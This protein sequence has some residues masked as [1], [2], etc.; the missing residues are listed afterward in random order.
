M[1]VYATNAIRGQEMISSA[2]RA[3]PGI[4]LSKV[5]FIQAKY[6]KK[7]FD[8]AVAQIMAA[9]KVSK[10]SQLTV[11][12]AAAAPDGSGVQVTARPPAVAQV[13]ARDSRIY[14]TANGAPGGPAIP[15]TVTAGS[16]VKAAT[17][18]W[19]DTAPFIGGDV[20]LGTSSA[21][22]EQCTSGVAAENSST[23]EDYIITAD[24]CY[25]IGTSV[26]G[27]GDPVGDW[28]GTCGNYVGEVTSGDDYWDA[29]IID[30][31]RQW[32]TGSIS[33]EAGK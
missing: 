3:H 28:Y 25:T 21:G 12:S 20:L 16:P 26:Y 5:K 13:R 23:G 9:S 14:A 2:R 29:Q 7:Q 4:D 31:G 33:A 30:T 22:E 1:D 11:Y 19:N 6:T 15:V 18:R 8:A 27:E 24:H 17:W 10:A 32:G